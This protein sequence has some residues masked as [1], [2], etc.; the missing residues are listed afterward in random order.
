M[1]KNI[2]KILS[3]V[4]LAT[5]MIPALA[6]AEWW[7]KNAPQSLVT[8]DGSGAANADI[9][10]RNCYIGL[11]TATP[12][13]GGASTIT[14][15]G[16]ANQVTY[17][18]GTHVVAGSNN[19]TFNGTAA[20]F[21]NA[22]TISSLTSGSVVFAGTAGLV[23]QDNSNFFF[24]NTNDYLGINLNGT[25]PTAQLDIQGDTSAAVLGSEMI[26][27]AADRDFSSNTGNWTGTNWT[28][29]GG[30][31][32]HTAGANTFTLSASALSTPI[33]SGG[34][35]QIQFTIATTTAGTITASVGGTTS[36][37]FGQATGTI[38]A[39]VN[40]LVSSVGAGTIVFTPD[41]S[42]A[43]TLDN[44]SLTLITPYSAV[45][46]FRNSSGTI[47]TEIRAG[48]N[49]GLNLFIGFGSGK[50][51]ISGT[52]NTFLGYNA[53]LYNSTG[54][55]NTFVGYNAGTLNSTAS[56]N[57]AMGNSALAST[58]TGATNVAIGRLALTA[59]T[60]AASNVAIGSS[61]LSSVITGGSNIG[62][63]A[64]AGG[65]LTT[66]IQN[67]M[68]GGGAYGNGATGDNNIVI[69]VSAMPGV[70]N[71]GSGN[72]TIGSSVQNLATTGSNNVVI[73]FQARSASGSASNQLSIGNLIYGTALDGRNATVSTGNIGIGLVAPATRLDVLGVSQTSS[74]A[75]G[76]LN[77]AQTWNTSGAPSF[78]LGNVTNTA[79]DSASLLMDL[80]VGAVSRFA[81]GVGGSPTSGTIFGARLQNNF[82]PASGTAVFSTLSLSSTINQ[83]GG[84]SGITRGLYVNPTLTAASDYRAIE[85]T[86]G[87]VSLP[88]TTSAAGTL[89]LANSTHYVFTGT[90][91][92][93][94][95]P[96]AS[97]NTGVTYF[98][99]NRGSG[100]ITLNAN[101]G[102]SE[103]YSTSGVATITINAG[104]SFILA[105][106]GTFWDV[107]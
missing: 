17:F 12:C 80:Q 75:T 83:T 37:N 20:T 26:T 1:K 102:A 85:A 70:G 15:S 87:K 81:I 57:V 29:G 51:N 103:I 49:N 19:L 36:L 63:G 28:I 60:T 47:Q 64:S 9:H 16:A 13:G 52:Q 90:T 54:G 18:T 56:N 46:N 42:W 41:A 107:E 68:I 74:S 55:S 67:I 77:L 66:G 100:A 44:I 34:I 91:T 71:S 31:A 105:D 89:I 78:I 14:G 25:A 62:I 104:E 96:A 73:G 5:V 6:S 11:G 99:K 61:A 50:T 88:V 27:L 98:I 22:P 72:I 58:T 45:Q 2:F 4:L 43:G 39:K 30:N 48:A 84:A 7:S 24:D 82:A 35:Y 33:V 38:N 101:G 94:T 79:S 76:T 106:D 53:G 97:G 69:G 10:V 65:F 21:A 40:L 32:T 8:N 86:L 59:S 95:L 23:S 93:W 92:T 3:F